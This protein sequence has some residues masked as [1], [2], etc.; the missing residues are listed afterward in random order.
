[1]VTFEDYLVVLKQKTMDKDAKK[2]VKELNDEKK[3]RRNNQGESKKH[4]PWL[5][6]HLEMQRKNDRIRF[7]Q[8]WNILIV[9]YASQ[10]FHHNFTAGLQAHPLGYQ[11]V[12]LKCMYKLQTLVRQ[13]AR[14]KMQV[15]EHIPTNLLQNNL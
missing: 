13:R 7:T 1:M 12:N 15:I 9:K 11:G 4:L 3:G 10:R 2:K 5:I 6:K 14:E 8:A